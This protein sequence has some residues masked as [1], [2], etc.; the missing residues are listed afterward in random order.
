MHPAKF[1]AQP[2]T[3]PR[4]RVNS[5]RGPNSQNLL[6][7]RNFPQTR[8]STVKKVGVGH[9]EIEP[10]ILRQWRT[11]TSFPKLPESIRL[12]AWK[13]VAFFRRVVGI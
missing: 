12:N 1:S 7:P 9:Y 3:P 10:S 8:P 11:S 2:R 4:S 5:G 6:A 13:H